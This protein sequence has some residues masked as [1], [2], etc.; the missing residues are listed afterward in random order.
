MSSWARSSSPIIGTAMKAKKT[1]IRVD[2]ADTLCNSATGEPSWSEPAYNPW[3]P[4]RRRLR[5]ARW[6]RT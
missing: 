6:R 4:L 3:A 1:E 2:F 5:T